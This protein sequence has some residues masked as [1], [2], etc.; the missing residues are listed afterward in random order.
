MLNSLNFLFLLLFLSIRAKICS[1]K[2]NSTSSPHVFSIGSSYPIQKHI[3]DWFHLTRRI[4]FTYNSISWTCTIVCTTRYWMEERCSYTC[5]KSL[6]IERHTIAYHR[7]SV[8][9]GIGKYD[10]QEC[11]CVCVR[12]AISRVRDENEMRENRVFYENRY[13]SMYIYVHRYTRS[14]NMY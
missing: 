12:I 4:H 11:V 3:T 5:N 13:Y 7:Q 9:I 10:S 1:T 6:I 2:N 8:I 14:K